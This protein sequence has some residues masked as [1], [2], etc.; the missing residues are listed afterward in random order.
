[1]AHGTYA[2]GV[3]FQSPGFAAL[4]RTLGHTD[5]RH[6]ITPTGLDNR[7]SFMAAFVMDDGLVTQAS[8]VCKTPLGFGWRMAWC[9]QGTRRSREPWALEC[10]AVGVKTIRCRRER[11]VDT[12]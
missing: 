6:A 5:K 8:R 2:E 3:R 10:N 7:S 9:T 12:D 4:P 11:L 1:M